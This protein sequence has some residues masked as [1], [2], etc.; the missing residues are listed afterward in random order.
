MATPNPFRGHR[1]NNPFMALPAGEVAL[2]DVPK[3]PDTHE[4]RKPLRA[5]LAVSSS[6]AGM[7]ADGLGAPGKKKVVE[8]VREAPE[9]PEA[10][11]AG[12]D[13]EPAPRVAR[14]R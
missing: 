4:P 2:L 3:A 8:Q 12:G 5:F 7:L 6:L 10:D 1:K 14:R 9:A 13:E 11:D